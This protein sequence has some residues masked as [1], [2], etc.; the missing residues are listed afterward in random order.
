MQ[1][2]GVRYTR[3]SFGPKSDVAPL[4]ARA[5]ELGYDQLEV[6][7]QMVAN[8]T[9]LGRKR[10]SLEARNHQMDLSYTLTL[11]PSFALCSTDDEIHRAGQAYLQ[12]IIS[13]IGEMGGGS[14]NGAL[15]GGFPC[16]WGM[17]SQHKQCFERSVQSLRMLSNYSNDEDVMLNIRPV[18][19]YTHFLIH[20]AEQA[21]LLVQAVNHPNCGIDL[22]TF[23]MNI[24][25]AN[26][27]KAIL[28]AGIYLRCVHLRENTGG[29]FGS[30]CLRWS[31]IKEALDALHYE[32]SLIHA[33]STGR[34]QEIAFYEGKR[35]KAFFN[36]KRPIQP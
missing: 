26:L 17:A 4:L 32:G 29:P 28:T 12:K 2:L 7:A 22:D 8:L 9:P 31:A 14:L 10:L 36:Q 15:Y 18:N 33:P 24:E 19:R 30:G 3:F 20:T 1:S 34:E 23:H 25:E 21:L 16:T 35:M 13:S 6:D 27:E 11:P 5:R